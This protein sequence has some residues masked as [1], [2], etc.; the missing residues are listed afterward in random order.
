M[1]IACGNTFILKPSEQ[2]PLTPM[3]LAELFEQAG[4]PKG[5][6][7]VVHGGKEQVD[8]LLN[9]PAIKRFRSWALFRL[10]ATFTKPVPAT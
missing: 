7:Q 6:L 10:V 1:A 3:R 8:T 9:D 4:A 5:V 2:D